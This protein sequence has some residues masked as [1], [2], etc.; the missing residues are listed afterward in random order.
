MD[1]R[2]LQFFRQSVISVFIVCIS[3]FICLTIFMRWR[4]ERAIKDTTGI[5]MSE[6]HQQ[7]RQKFTSII[8]LRLEQ[9]EGITQFYPPENAVYGEQMLDSLTTNIKLRNFSYAGLYSNNGVLENIYGEQISLTKESDMTKMIRSGMNIVTEAVNRHGE[10]MLI[11]GKQ[12]DYPMRDGETSEVL[13][14]GLPMEYLDEVLFLNENNS[15]LYFHIIDT[16][17][18][19]VIRSGDAFRENYFDRIRARFDVLNGKKPEEYVKELSHAMKMQEAYSAVISMNGQETHLYCSPLSENSRWYLIAAMPNNT[20]LR[21]VSELDHIRTAVTFASAAAILFAMSVIFFLY[22]RLSQRQMKELVKARNEADFSNAAKSRFLSSM[23][24]EI[25]TPMN[26][27]IGMTEIAQRNL[28]DPDRVSDCLN[29]VRLSSKHLLGLIND[30]LDMSKIESK[31]MTLNMAPISLRDTMDDI[32]NIIQPQIKEKGQHF[33]IFIQ[34]IISENVHCDDVRLNQA[35]INILSNAV[36]YT[37]QEG[38]VYI[39]VNQEPSPMGEAYVR[40]HFAVKDT[41]IGMTPEFQSKIWD[42]FSGSHKMMKYG[43]LWEPALA[44]LLPKA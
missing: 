13:L 3:V 10:K 29:K 38:S 20:L 5:Y 8:H 2:T 1:K 26:A 28:K 16:G 41:G 34:N 14:V 21:S 7:I 12:A 15:L 4:T 22:Y 24:H 30:V 17:G 25:R 27:I 11:L 6:M 42:T 39:Y 37:P 33:D 36:K 32:V 31:K 40:T 18:H 19:F 23:S 9:V 44:C 35:L 43:I